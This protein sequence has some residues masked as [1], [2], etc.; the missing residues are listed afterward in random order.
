[1]NYT[2]LK[3]AI[4][5]RELEEPSLFSAFNLIEVLLKDYKEESESKNYSKI[6]L[7][8]EEVANKL[9]WLIDTLCC[10]YKENKNEFQTNKEKLEKKNTE[11]E[12]IKKELEKYRIDENST[13]EK[14][15]EL[16]E[17]REKLEGYER[18]D[19]DIEEHKEKIRS[20]RQ[21]ESDKIN[22][23]NLILQEIKEKED[24]IQAEMDSITICRA[25]WNDK[26]KEITGDLKKEKECLNNVFD[27]L[28][29]YDSELKN[30]INEVIENIAETVLSIGKTQEKLS[31][32]NQELQKKKEKLT[33]GEGELDNLLKME[34]ER[35]KELNG[36]KNKEDLCS[37]LNGRIKELESDIEDK[38]RFINE[39]TELSKRIQEYERKIKEIEKQ[40]DSAG[41]DSKRSIENIAATK[42]III[43]EFRKTVDSYE[44]AYN[45]LFDEDENRRSEYWDNVEE[46]I[47]RLEKLEAITKKL[48]EDTNYLSIPVFNSRTGIESC[49]DLKTRLRDFIDY[50]K[51]EID[52]YIKHYT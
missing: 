41:N 52:D 31:K 11:A 8:D 40:I 19:K 7:G 36:L 28:E 34:E 47:E 26:R 2:F 39:E 48:N 42:T 43:R 3:T 33:S 12:R 16:K 25:R 27:Q 32:R 17:L 30:N 44:R 35:E 18:L 9:Y 14:E 24:K 37:R 49:L 20:I 10:I 5:R 51:K 15:N 13:E 29:E 45:G 22:E 1:M 38:K 50:I 23:K 46:L 6:P 21:D 4:G